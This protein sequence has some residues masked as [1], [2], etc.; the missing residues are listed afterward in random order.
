MPPD[1]TY[2]VV[3]EALPWG[4]ASEHCLKNGGQLAR[5]RNEYIEGFVEQL[6]YQ[7]EEDGKLHVNFTVL[8]FF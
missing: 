4:K 2:T 5:I 3:D 8:T 1:H 7:F 6:L